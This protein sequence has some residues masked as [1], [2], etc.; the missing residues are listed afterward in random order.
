[1]STNKVYGDVPN[2][3]PMTELKTRWDYADPAY[4][5][6]IPERRAFL[7]RQYYRQACTIIDKR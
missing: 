3:I 1:M 7:S 4:K 5:H 6:G 2:E